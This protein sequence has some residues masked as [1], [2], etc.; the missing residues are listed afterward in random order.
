VF[1]FVTSVK[2]VTRPALR[3]GPEE[4]LLYVGTQHMQENLCFTACTTCASRVLLFVAAFGRHHMLPHLHAL[5]SVVGV[6]Q[7]VWAFPVVEKRH[8]CRA[9]PTC[10]LAKNII[11]MMYCSWGALARLSQKLL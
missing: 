3:Y 4:A 7:C 1:L 10:A 2:A 9:P 11:E 5:L 8:C 6:L